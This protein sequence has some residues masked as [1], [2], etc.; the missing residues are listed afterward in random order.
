M[1]L[2]PGYQYIYPREDLQENR[3]VDAA[4]FAVRLDQVCDGR[5][6]RRLSGPGPLLQPEHTPFGGGEQI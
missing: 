6:A 5:A 4:E 2:K 1:A 3:P